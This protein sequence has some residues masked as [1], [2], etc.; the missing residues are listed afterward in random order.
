MQVSSGMYV[1]VYEGDASLRVST[2]GDEKSLGKKSRVLPK[3][4]IIHSDD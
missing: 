1:K 2:E 3:S 4:R